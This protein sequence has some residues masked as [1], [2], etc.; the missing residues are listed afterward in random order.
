LRAVRNSVRVVSVAAARRNPVIATHHSARSAIEPASRGSAGIGKPYQKGRRRTAVLPVERDAD[1]Q[2]QMRDAAPLA[3]PDRLVGRRDSAKIADLEAL[4]A[5]HQHALAAARRGGAHRQPPGYP[6]RRGVSGERY[7]V[8]P[9]AAVI[10][11]AEKAETCRLAAKTG[12][13]SGGDRDR[14]RQCAAQQ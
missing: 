9:G 4:D 13:A 3:M 11:Q 14:R 10:D 2:R 6:D 8:K 7:P 5:L 1:K 12:L